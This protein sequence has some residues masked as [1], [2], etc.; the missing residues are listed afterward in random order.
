MEPVLAYNPVNPAVSPTLPTDVIRLSAATQY[1]FVPQLPR[2]NGCSKMHDQ[3][4]SELHLFIT[5]NTACIGPALESAKL[6]MS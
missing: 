6:D 4:F 5:L 3:C 2:L 1:L